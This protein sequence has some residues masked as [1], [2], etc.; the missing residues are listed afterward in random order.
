MSWKSCQAALASANALT[1]PVSPVRELRHVAVDRRQLGLV[2]LEGLRLTSDGPLFLGGCRLSLRL[3]GGAQVL[4]LE[5]RRGGTFR[6]LLELGLPF[7]ELV[8]EARPAGTTRWQQRQRLPQRSHLLLT[9]GERARRLQRGGLGH[10]VVESADAGH[11][12]WRQGVQRR[13]IEVL[14]RCEAHPYR[15]V[16]SRRDGG[17]CGDLGRDHGRK[18]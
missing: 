13:R 1:M 4:H 6:E 17:G 12:K 2:P 3:L 11:G 9:L 8:L 7:G 14:Q 18:G 5:L 16:G 15:F 10:D